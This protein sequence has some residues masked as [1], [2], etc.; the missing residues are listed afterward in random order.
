[1]AAPRGPAPGR[2]SMTRLAIVLSVLAVALSAF[3][4]YDRFGGCS[5]CEK[6]AEPEAGS[7]PAA[8]DRLAAVERRLQA[9]EMRPEPLA[10]P[11]AR[12]GTPATDGAATLAAGARP[13][14]RAVA[15]SSA[16]EEMEKRLQA[17]EE[18][19]AKAEEEA[20]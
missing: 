15:A 16:V 1:G 9:L 18:Y 13:A 20:K 8:E 3:L 19:R 10:A 6:R 7:P 12:G 5:S 2:I 14:G 4:A 17:L 11:S